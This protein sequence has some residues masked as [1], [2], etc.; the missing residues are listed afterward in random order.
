MIFAQIFATIYSLIKLELDAS[1]Q[2]QSAG[3]GKLELNI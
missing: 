3:F 2:S 1:S